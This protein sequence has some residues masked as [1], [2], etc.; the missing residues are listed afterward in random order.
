MVARDT[1]PTTATRNYRSLCSARLEEPEPTTIR[2]DDKRRL[3]IAS[4]IDRDITTLLRAR[5]NATLR[6]GSLWSAGLQTRGRAER[7][8]APRRDVAPLAQ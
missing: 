7:G 8:H 3:A 4:P 6:D 1:A 2:A 5:P